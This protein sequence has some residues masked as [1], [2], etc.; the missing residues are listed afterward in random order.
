MEQKDIDLMTLPETPGVYI[1]Y[2][3]KNTVL[4][5]GRATNLRSRVRS[6]FSD[7]LIADRGPRIMEAVKKAERAEVKETDSVLEAY[8]LEA[9]MIKKYQPPHNVVDKD[10]KSFQFVGITKED[11]PRVLV[12]RGRQLE[13]GIPGTSFSHIY[14]PFPKGSLLK[15][16]LK[17]LRKILPFRDRCTPPHLLKKTA[18]QV[19]SGAAQLMSGHMCRINGSRRVCKTNS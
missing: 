9:N 19:F 13:Q 11:F 17:I 18:P 5:V 8:I 10:N 2:G 1:F 6:Y 3:E 15:E 12:I 16:A 4:Y 7:R 14:G